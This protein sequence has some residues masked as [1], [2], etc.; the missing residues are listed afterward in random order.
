MMKMKRLSVLLCICIAAI[1][2]T[3]SSCSK[4]KSVESSS[5]IDIVYLRDYGAI[6]NDGIDDVRAIKKALMDCK[7]DGAKKL[8]FEKGQYDFFPTFSGERYCFISNNDEGLKRIAFDLKDINNLTIDGQ[9]AQLMFH[10]FISP[11]VVEDSQNIKFENFSID[12]SRTFHSESIILGYDADGM[13]VEIREGFPFKVYRGTLLFTDG[14]KQEGELTTVSKSVTYG[15]SHMLEY[16]TEKRE[17]AY[18]VK[19]FYFSDING[20]PAKELG[21][22]KVRI[23]VPG[24]TGTIGNTMVFGPNHRKHPSFVVSDS[25]NI[26]FYNVTIYHSGGMGILGQRSHNITVDECKVTPSDGRMI[27]ATADAT[28]FVNCTGKIALTNNLFEN[29]KDDAT[30]IH[31]I[32]AQVIEKSADDKIIV[33]LKHQQQHAFDFM[34]PGMELELVRGKSMITYDTAIVKHVNRINKEVTEVTFDKNLPANLEIGDAVA[35]VRDYPEI[36]IS[37]NIIRNNRARGMLLNCRGKTVVENNTFHSPG[38]AI[39]FEGDSFFWFE[40]GGVRDCVIRNNNFENCLYGV[41]GKAII[42]V[43]AG[44]LEN[45]EISRYNRNILI[46]NNTFK[47]YDD[48]TLL[49]AYCV[50]GLIWRNNTVEK[51]DAY[52]ET[53][54]SYKRF[55]VNY[56]DNVQIDDQNDH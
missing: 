28:H 3:V 49:N 37:G 54:K 29:Q 5:N 32:Y 9:G 40:Q 17:T 16:D 50:D 10:G 43:K 6:T 34:K 31:G 46:E 48:L 39:L 26:D 12:Y 11:F 42:D 38:A 47:I 53:G 25:R 27:S 18:M 41:W 22:R 45:K 52:P 24:L 44:V 23:R 20:F 21:G 35:E 55:V 36:L 2:T 8:V 33:Q 56:C 30:N 7:T 1:L 51:T 15:S 14:Q 13:D 4:N 19:D